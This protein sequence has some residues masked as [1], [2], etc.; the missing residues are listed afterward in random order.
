MDIIGVIDE[1]IKFGTNLAF[2][3]GR[4]SLNFG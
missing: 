4:R 2:A 3:E 1:L